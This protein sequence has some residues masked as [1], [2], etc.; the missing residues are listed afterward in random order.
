[1]S[2]NWKYIIMSSCPGIGASVPPAD[3]FHL[4]TTLAFLTPGSDAWR[5]LPVTKTD[6]RGSTHYRDKRSWAKWEQKYSYAAQLAGHVLGSA[7]MLDVK[8]PLPIL[9]KDGPDSMFAMGMDAGDHP[10]AKPFGLEGEMPYN[11]LPYMASFFEGRIYVVRC[12]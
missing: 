1:M 3:Q 5:S 6:P 7:T 8:L 4:E 9:P 12:C 10:A 11:M 2:R